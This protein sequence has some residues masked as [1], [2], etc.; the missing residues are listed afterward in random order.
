MEKTGSLISPVHSYCADL[1]SPGAFYLVLVLC[2]ACRLRMSRG[3]ID[4]LCTS[5]L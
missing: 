1:L 3:Y 5:M 4:S 2:L